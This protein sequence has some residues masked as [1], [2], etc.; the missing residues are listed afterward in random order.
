MPQIG[1][2]D[3]PSAWGVPCAADNAQ[4]NLEVDKVCILEDIIDLDPAWEVAHKI[5]AL[6]L[7]QGG[8]PPRSP[9]LS[10]LADLKAKHRD[11]YKKILKVIRL[12]GERDRVRNEQHVKQSKKWPEIYEM[13]GGKARLFFFYSNYDNQIVICTNVYHKRDDSKR[14]QDAGFEQCN[15][16]RL[17]YE[18]YRSKIQAGTLL[19][20]NRNT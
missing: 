9:A 16:L 7:S 1:T 19:P 3:S 15:R 11:D 13:R 6:A 4:V 12:V 14:L 20:S 18:E 10:G 2:S 5:R 8:G 17:I